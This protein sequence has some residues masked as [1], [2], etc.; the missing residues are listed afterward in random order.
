[1]RP[2]RRDAPALLIF[3]LSALFLF[4]TVRTGPEGGDSAELIASA[5]SLG[6]AHA[7]GYPLYVCL[8]R[9]A[10]LLHADPNDAPLVMNGLSALFGAAAITLFAFALREATGTLLPGALAV[11]ALAAARPFWY[12]ATFAEVYTLH[13]FL[14]ATTFFLL[15]RWRR[16]GDRRMIFLAVYVAA[17][18]GAHHGGALLF[19][20]GY[21]LFLLTARKKLPPP[22]TLLASLVLVPIAFSVYAYLPLR[23]GCAPPVD[24]F[25]DIDRKVEWGLI[26]RETAGDTFA[27]RFLYK[28]EGSGPRRKLSW[29]GEAAARN[30]PVFP[31]YFRDSVGVLFLGLG[32]AGLLRALI[33][34]PRGPGFLLLY[35]FFVNTL[36]CLN[37]LS[38]DIDD[39]LVPSL[40]FISAGTA[41]L[42]EDVRRL[43]G[44]ATRGRRAAG[45]L[46]LLVLF[47]VNSAD[48]VRRNRTNKGYRHIPGTMEKERELI[49]APLPE[50][51]RILLPWGRAAA[52]R[53][54]QVVEGIRPD[55]EFHPMGRKNYLKVAEEIAGETPLFVENVDGPTRRRFQVT[56]RWGLFELRRIDQGDSR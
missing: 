28:I 9:I 13:L 24:A 17:M 34:G 45:T 46:V 21:A 3:A 20:P 18:N 54:L 7:T 35:C 5:W 8:G 44:L 42:L 10:L 23:H 56:A 19:A 11:A 29:F 53:Y 16:T 2:V 48:V 6:I 4:V 14:L 30:G 51:A 37:F 40:F 55:I 26:D 22:T 50:N 33:A 41:F 38:L 27:Q 52:L 31:R 25:D 12:V 15:F 32:A 1:M 47:T 49:N 36:F 43:I 39:F